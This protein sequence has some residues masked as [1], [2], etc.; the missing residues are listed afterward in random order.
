MSKIEER[1][2]APRARADLPLQLQTTEAAARRP[3]E[4]KDISR[5]GLCC[6][7]PE[8]VAE[9]TVMGVDLALPGVGPHRVQGVVVRCERSR[10]EPAYDVAIYF[11]D[12][13]PAARKDIDRFVAG[14]I[15]RG[16]E[17]AR[18]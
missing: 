8:P 16:R 6:S 12:V 17:A 10:G 1:R 13:P 3:A 7:F 4:L 2:G 5:S 18:P 11:T 15:A 14:A 9:M